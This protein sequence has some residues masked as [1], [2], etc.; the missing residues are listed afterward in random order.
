M[1]TDQP[2]PTCSAQYERRGR[3]QPGDRIV[4]CTLPAGHQREHV[5]EE[6]GFAWLPVDVTPDP[7]LH[8]HDVV[9]AAPG[10]ADCPS[11][12]VGPATDP[13]TQ[14]DV[15]AAYERGKADVAPGVKSYIEFLEGAGEQLADERDEARAEVERLQALLVHAEQYARDLQ[16]SSTLERAVEDLADVQ[17]VAARA[18]RNCEPLDPGTVLDIVGWPTGAPD[19]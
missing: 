15:D 17:Q 8:A 7:G 14:A 5:E 1:P 2:T 18:Q 6:T 3:R 4:E 11:K 10:C 12:G 19:A 13:V 9:D 16:D